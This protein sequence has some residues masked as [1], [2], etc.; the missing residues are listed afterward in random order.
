MKRHLLAAAL[1][2]PM[3]VLA[4]GAA[5]PASAPAS[6]SLPAAA[7]ATASP[8]LRSGLDTSA[9]DPSVRPQDDLFRAVNGAWLKATEIPADKPEY[10]TFIE[11]RDRADE[12]VR[13]IVEEL[14][15]ARDLQGNE[16]R[17]ADFYR[18]AMDTRA[19]DAAGF[20]PVRPWFEL[21]DAT[22]DA[23]ALSHLLGRLQGVAEMPLVQ[24]VGPDD[25]APDTYVLHLWQGGLGLPDRDYYLKDDPAMAKAREAYRTYQRALLGA[26]GEAEALAQVDAVYALEERL[27]RAQ[28]ARVDLRDPKKLYNPTTR[29]RLVRSAP[30]VDWTNY[31]GAGALPQDLRK[32]VVAQPSY[33]AELAKAVRE[34]PLPVW[35]AYLKLRVLDAQADWL[36]Q[37]VRDA[38]FAY[39][40]TALAG[41]TAPKPRW[42]KATA[43]LDAALGEA[44]G[45]VYVQRH[46][47]PAYKARMQELVNH[48]LGAYR[49]SIDGL[50][51][52][53][54][55]TKAR[56]RDKLAKYTTKIG[57]PE[58]WRDY[59]RLEIRPGDAFGNVVRAGRFEHERQAVR[60]GR[61]V[62]RR[63]WGMTPQTV[64]AYYNPSFNEIVFPAAILEPPF[65]DMRA[66]DAVN[67]GAIGA[68]IG[69]EIS[70]GFDDWG[71]QYDGEGRLR[72]WW[73]AADRK[74]FEALGAQL[75]AQ[76]GAYQPL[77]GQSLNGQLTL[78]ENIADL[79]GLQIAWKAWQRSL[80]GRPAPVID[81]LGGEQRFFMG[82][83]QSWREKTREQRALQLL[84]VD[85][86]S[87]P[88]FRANGAAVNHDAFHQA[89]GTRQGD[90]MYKPAE[91]RLR[92]W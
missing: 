79:S 80:G 37:P 44:V 89:F 29:N 83:A 45:Q 20:A 90:G 63:E 53:S 10:G 42:Q 19:I 75:V 25:K 40:D 41:L 14:A 68:I 70:H 86:H 88:E 31:F 33:V 8:V 65:F 16:R 92:I 28:W 66:D 11:L 23:R 73:T 38:R 85:P 30:Q 4:Q 27:A 12:R 77:P 43:A 15:A 21:I 69:H 82:W 64:N 87:P 74:A 34:V 59:S 18:S 7:S 72:N 6:A 78:G 35:N 62:D 22:R 17:I 55:A 52:M 39:R 60:A 67:Y 54:P 46:F 3:T 26:A 24:Y 2:L 48:L 57:Y 36:P 84:T 47:P 49:E 76:Y 32:V 81:G 56:A 61:K 5:A 58:V 50:G 51:W 71:S 9:F 1:A 13:R 91:R